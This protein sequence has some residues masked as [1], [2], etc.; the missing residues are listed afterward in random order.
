VMPVLEVWQNTKDFAF[1]NYP[2]GSQGPE[3]AMKLFPEWRQL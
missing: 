1:P 2:A 3:S